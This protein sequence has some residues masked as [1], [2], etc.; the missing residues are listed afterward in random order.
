MILM[1][2]FLYKPTR[3][4]PVTMLFV[5]CSLLNFPRRTQALTLWKP[6]FPETDELSSPP[7][8]Q[9]G[10]SDP[11]LWLDKDIYSD[12]IQQ[13]KNPSLGNSA[14][15]EAVDSEVD[16]QIEEQLE[17]QKSN[18]FPTETVDTEVDEEIEE[19]LE[20][21]KLSNLP[22]IDLIETENPLLKTWFVEPPKFPQFSY[23]KLVTLVVDRHQWQAER[24]MGQYVFMNRFGTTAREYDY[25][26]RVCNDKGETVGYFFCPLEESQTQSEEKNRSCISL[27]S[28]GF[29][30]R[31]FRIFDILES[32]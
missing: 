4:I 31:D 9:T 25:H 17:E 7:L 29:R 32:E 23:N 3:L 30:L 15:R 11:S 1:Q 10:L 22:P 12:V 26:V 5:W 24:Y 14:G 16:E 8:S 21:Q 27:R 6:C 2:R 20:E 28:E 13:T 19:Q 18:Q